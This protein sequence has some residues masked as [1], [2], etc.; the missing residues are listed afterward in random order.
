MITVQAQSAVELQNQL[1]PEKEE[2]NESILPSRGKNEELT[3][4]FKGRKKY[5]DVADAAQAAFESAAYAAAAA[6]A[7]V[8]LSRSQSH[9]PDDHDSPGPQTRKVEDGQ[10]NAK[11]QME[12]EIFS[13]TQGEDFNKDIDELKGSKDFISRNSTDKVLMGT[14]ASV[15][16]E[17]E[18]DPFK[19]EVVFDD[20]DDETDN[21]QNKN[22]SSEKTSSGYGAG[23]DVNSGSR[24]LVLNTVSESKMQGVPQLD[25]HKRPISVRSR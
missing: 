10:D 3:D 16:A 7:A 9:D 12:K 25:L 22:E 11:H 19:E 8:E 18:G 20:S 17:I 1:G 6:R 5:K 23:I 2:E 4:S 21:N 14:N 13:E 24:K 15:D